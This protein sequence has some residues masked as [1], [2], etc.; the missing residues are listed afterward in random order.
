MYRFSGF[1]LAVVALLAS[2]LAE[3]Q[4]TTGT[5]LGTIRDESG[6][7]LPGATASITSPA[8]IGGPREVITGESGLFRFPNLSPGIYTLT[9][10]LAGFSTYTE[11]G[12]R[13]VV[14]G[15]V[16]RNVVLS[17][18]SVAETITVTGESPVVDTKATDIST[19]YTREWVENAP[20]RR[21]TFFDLINA[22]PGV[23]Q[24]TQTSSRSSSFG[25]GTDDNSYQLDG[26]DFTAPLTG[27]AWPWPNTDT[28]EEIEIL[29]LGATAEYGNLQGAVFN[30]VTKQ[31][32]NALDGSVN[33]YFQHDNLTGRNTT[34]EQDDGLPYYRDKFN[35]FTANVGGPVVKD[36]FWFF[37]SYQYQRDYEAQPGTDPSAP[38]KSDADRYFFKLT[39][40]VNQNN[41]LM[42]ANHD[43][44]Y[45]IPFRQTAV[46]GPESIQ[47][48]Y[49]HNPSPNVT[50]TS[51][52]DDKTWFEARYS[53]FYG[54]DHAEPLQP[55]LARSRPR[56]YDT[57]T[58]FISG[59]TYSWYD[60]VSQKTAFAGKITRFADNFLGGSHDFKF[61]VQY[62]SGGGK[63]TYAYNDYIYTYYG[64]PLY[65]YTQL[66]LQQVGWVKGIGV[67][68][69]DSW[70]IGDNLT[71][72]L[73]VRFDRQ[74][75]S[76]P[77]SEVV[78]SDGNPTG[79]VNSEVS[80]LFTWTN[81][82][83]RLGFN[84]KLTGDGRTT[85]KGHWGRYN[86]GVVTGEF[87]GA[88]PGI[89][90]RF[91][92]SGLYDASGAPIGTE[93]FS[94]NTQLQ[95]D[96]DYKN[97]YTD[98]FILGFD[99]EIAQDF[100]F[101][102]NYVYKRG[103][104]ASAWQD[105]AGEYEQTT[106]VDNEGTN[107]TGASFPVYRLLSDPADRIFLLTN[108]D[109]S[110]RG[111][112]TFT[113]YQG[114]TLQATKRMS[115]HWQMT[116]SLVLSKATGIIASSTASPTGGT[117]TNAGNNFGRNPNEYVNLNEDSV[118]TND[119]PTNF[120][121]QFVYELPAE[122]TL[123]TN[124]TYQSGK[125]WERQIRVPDL[126]IPTTLYAEPFDGERRVAD[127][128]QLD[129]R[130]QKAFALGADARLAVFG[131]ALNL[132]NDDAYENIGSRVGT[133]SSFGLPTRFLLPRRLMV[134]AK[135]I[136]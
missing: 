30:V 108:P 4:I 65:G 85:L 124:F 41:K 90:P 99:R 116:A 102:V 6:G 36:K 76:F 56:Y 101:S 119:R 45:R 126:G 117:A 51:V 77:E 15:T 96:P 88:G 9:V 127:W 84:L 105:I 34:D 24:N 18:E 52:I 44:F 11:E 93:L 82:S 121:L 79:Q 29:S 25:S 122:V 26:T 94:D 71:V 128:Y 20:I 106:Y 58:G 42:V 21:F 40:Q 74:R 43:D 17:L 132:F 134:G 7:V 97:P 57:A 129:V 133:A 53:G 69:D 112:E 131:D 72:N 73:G 61:G 32:G 46:E 49:G 89:T 70:N 55:G 111:E 120:R 109:P 135:F 130:V 5:L 2:S 10:S 37:G 35:D 12:L 95:V 136:F 48:E 68:A 125:P 67:F 54:Q 87:Q 13:V 91:I 83:P 23:S 98:Q 14:G 19:N 3:A 115:N 39:Y 22:A 50:W 114:V 113:R 75:A 27:A 123:G 104:R 80:N 81:V 62:N 103:E 38:A 60:G 78:D 63:Y 8:L 107:A 1:V 28:I 31:G 16:E 47:L 92:F 66:P 86:K 118:L 59:G 100:A 64:E 33:F 110:I